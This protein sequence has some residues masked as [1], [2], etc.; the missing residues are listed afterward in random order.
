MCLWR[1][2][3]ACFLYKVGKEVIV[4]M[5]FHRFG[6]LCPKA[7][8]S[9]FLFFAVGRTAYN[10]GTDAVVFWVW[11]FLRVC[12]PIWDAY[13]VWFS[14]KSLPTTGTV[15]SWRVLSRG[16]RFP[17]ACGGIGSVRAF[18]VPGRSLVFFGLF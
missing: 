12:P 3:S 10:V 6:K 18:Q 16:R 9:D 2:T 8:T 5:S 11:V 7:S 15:S 4:L 13:L 1:S 14:H 17:G